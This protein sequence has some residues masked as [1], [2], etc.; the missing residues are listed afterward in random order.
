[1]SNT[2]EH[3]STQMRWFFVCNSRSDFAYIGYT[4]TLEVTSSQARPS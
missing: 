4:R 2:A 3:Q 1:M